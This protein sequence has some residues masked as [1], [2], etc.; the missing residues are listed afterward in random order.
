[1]AKI[2]VRGG[3]DLQIKF[4]D[5]GGADI[6]PIAIDAVTA[7]GPWYYVKDGNARIQANQRGRYYFRSSG[8]MEVDFKST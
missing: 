5:E 1:M 8:D 4:T 2:H 6:F 7:K 3:S